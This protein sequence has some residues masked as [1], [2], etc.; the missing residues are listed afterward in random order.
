MEV[1]ARTRFF[2]F[3]TQ[4]PRLLAFAFFLSSAVVQAGLERWEQLGPAD[5]YIR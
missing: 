3:F 1:S 4:L 2:A 5:A